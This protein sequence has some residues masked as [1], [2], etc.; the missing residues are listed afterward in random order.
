[1]TTGLDVQRGC[2]NDVSGEAEQTVGYF[3]NGVEGDGDEAVEVGETENSR[4][5]KESKSLRHLDSVEVDGETCIAV[6]Q[7]YNT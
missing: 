5:N 1:M 3:N 7:H 6:G 2:T 4:I